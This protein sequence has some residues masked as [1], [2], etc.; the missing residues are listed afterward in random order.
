MR[1]GTEMAGPAKAAKESKA[2]KDR[3]PAGQTA[4]DLGTLPNQLGY[5]LRRAQVAVIQSYAAA[6]AEAGLRPAQYSVLTVLEC[7]P[8]LSP[9]A[10]ADALAIT[11]TNFVPLFDSLVRRALAERRPV[12]TNRRTQA[13]YLTPAGKALLDQTSKLLSRHEKL[14]AA[15][16]GGANAGLL[17]NLLQEL[18]DGLAGNEIAPSDPAAPSRRPRRSRRSRLDGFV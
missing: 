9:S 1:Q 16:L 12:A 17:L 6:F 2:D 10:V 4:V 14:F 7:N 13:L 3:E 5:V 11:R 18:V 8:G 15:K